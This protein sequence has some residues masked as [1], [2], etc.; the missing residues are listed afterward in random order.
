MSLIG[1]III[2]N[3]IMV[4]NQTVNNA[5][6]TPKLGTRWNEYIDNLNIILIVILLLFYLI[7]TGQ[8]FSS[9]KN[10]MIYLHQYVEQNPFVINTSCDTFEIMISNSSFFLFVCLFDLF[11]T[12]PLQ[13]PWNN[14][15]QCGTFPIV[16]VH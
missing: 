6:F 3:N 10:T 5:Q 8:I 4:N 1:Q 14:V 2:L 15:E 16:G 12:L 11:T 7:F 9:K 13:L